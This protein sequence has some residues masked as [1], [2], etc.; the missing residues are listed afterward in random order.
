MRRKRNDRSIS[1][2]LCVLLLLPGIL[3][4]CGTAE[5]R[6][7]VPAE[8]TAPAGMSPDR[9]PRPAGEKAAGTRASAETQI[10]EPDQEEFGSDY[11]PY[12]TSREQEQLESELQ[13]I[14]ELCRE[15][16]RNAEWIPPRSEEEE[17]ELSSADA[18]SMEAVLTEAGFSVI[19]SDFDYP[20]YLENSGRLRDFWENVL[21]NQNADA[22]VWSISASGTVE[23]LWFQYTDG[24]KSCILAGSEWDDDGALH[25]SYAGK[26]EV[27]YWEM[28]GHGLLYQIMPMNRHWNATQLIRIRPSDH[29]LT[30]LTRKYVEPIGYHNVNLFLLD[31]SSGDFGNLC[32]N[33]LLS[34]LYQMETGD[35]L[36][37][38]DYPYTDE[39]FPHSIVPAD[40]MES[41]VYRHFDLPLE[42]FRK[43]ALYDAGT[44]SYPWQDL[45]FDNV[46]YY[47]DVQPEITEVTQN[48]D[49]TV[50]LHVTVICPDNHTDRLFDHEVTMLLEPDGGFRYLANRITY[51]GDCE[52]PSPQTRI[53]LQRFDASDGNDG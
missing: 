2:A 30:D 19:N 36:Y 8:R 29:T 32:F 48:G 49:G 12:T 43:K 42:S 16:Y 38:Q 5:E 1:Y 11:A 18:A 13:K 41:V 37:A 9:L 24:H 28:T 40:L 15:L 6:R 7:P 34:N 25:L 26:K 35:Y 3:T 23:C 17:A 47:P 4:G 44:D 31:W 51:R 52:L 39:P 53:P 21:A 33:D 50:T 45:Y 46:I 20:D 10:P 27:L 22:A 14:G